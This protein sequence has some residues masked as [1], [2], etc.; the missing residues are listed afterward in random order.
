MAHTDPTAA[1]GAPSARATAY[2]PREFR[3]DGQTTISLALAFALLAG[4]VQYGRQ[5]ERLAMVEKEIAKLTV[6]IDLLTTA[7]MQTRPAV[8]KQETH[9]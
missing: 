2:P 8:A 1:T 5:S 3:L 6:K 9:P 4:G 7:L